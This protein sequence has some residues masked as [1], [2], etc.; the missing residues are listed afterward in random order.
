VRSSQSERA[1]PEACAG[2]LVGVHL[3]VTGGRPSSYPASTEEDRLALMKTRM[4]VV[5]E[6]H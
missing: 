5:F 3:A 1:D 6:R 4:A 2:L